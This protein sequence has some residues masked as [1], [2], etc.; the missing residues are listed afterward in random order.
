MR[1]AGTA[2]NVHASRSTPAKANAVR[3][4]VDGSVAETSKALQFVRAQR[5]D[6]GPRR[7][8]VRLLPCRYECC[9][10][11]RRRAARLSLLYH[12]SPMPLASG[13]RAL[14]P[15]VT[16]AFETRVSTWREAL[17]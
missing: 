11:C 16:V 9:R 1:V 4:K 6:E 10:S 2:G 17:R 3:A 15:E 14:L 7:V 8:T 5:S 13:T 12:G